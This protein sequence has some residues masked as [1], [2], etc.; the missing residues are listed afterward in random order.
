[1]RTILIDGDIVLYEIATSCE[2]ATDWGDD[3]WTYHC[4]FKEA[5]QR[6]DCWISDMQERLEADRVIIAMSGSQNWRKEVLPEYKH[7]RKKRRKPMIF[8]ALKE[9]SNEVYKTY[10]FDDLEAD[11][12]LGLLAGEPGI[13]KLTGEKIVVTIDKDL[14][15]I[16]GLHYNPMRPQ[17]GICEV[18]KDQADYNHYFQTLTG[19]SVDGYSG[20]PGIGP[21]RAARV[22]AHPCW[23]AVI[24][25]YGTAGLT[26]E[27]A[28]VQAR[29]AR[30]LRYGEYNVK[31]GLVN[32]WEP[33]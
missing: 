8:K 28:L 25:A 19:D 33:K 9:Y 32:L 12:V 6:Y 29:V 21:K 3:M 5:K 2:V 27:D 17:E 31:K 13:A 23:G 10:Q 15:T 30:I 1:M 7:H 18:T 11:D 24:E 26:E 20:C 22:L 14:K 4:D 16:P